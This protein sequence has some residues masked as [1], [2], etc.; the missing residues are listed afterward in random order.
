MKNFKTEIRNVFEKGLKPYGFVKAKCKNPYYV[1]LINNEIL[2][3]ISYKEE[4]S[5]IHSKAF[6]VTFGIATIYR[7]EIGLE[8]SSG[9][10]NNAL[11]E[12]RRIPYLIE[13]CEIYKEVIPY[14]MGYD[15]SDESG[16]GNI[17]DKAFELT[18]TFALPILD[19]VNTLEECIN[20]FLKYH[21]SVMNFYA[22]DGYVLRWK[23]DH[24]NE[25]LLYTLVYGVERREE[26]MKRMEELY[27]EI[28]ERELNKIINGKSRLTLEE[29]E[30]NNIDRQEG[31]QQLINDYTLLV[32]EPEWVS[33]VSEQMVSRKANNIAILKRCGIIEEA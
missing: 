7:K 15:L 29:H 24:N 3:I 2:H 6:V 21:P 13:N 23:C 33:K 5:I 12:L 8:I 1:R 20:Y 16:M 26:F 27:K 25:G 11:E 32:I 14:E 28:S 10:L 19:K 30:K 31:L 17:I 9:I 18:E 4:Q 22:D